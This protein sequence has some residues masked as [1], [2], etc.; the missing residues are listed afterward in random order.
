MVEGGQR[1]EDEGG[2]GR[3]REGKTNLIFFSSLPIQS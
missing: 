3:E 2:E 1:K